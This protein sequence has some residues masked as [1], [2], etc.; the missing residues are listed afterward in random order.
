MI[1]Y[2]K[3]S[4]ACFRIHPSNKQKIVVYSFEDTNE[5]QREG[6]EASS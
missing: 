3:K 4:V 5:L 2:I 6:W 1:I